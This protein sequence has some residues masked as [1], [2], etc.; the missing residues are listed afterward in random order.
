MAEIAAGRPPALANLPREPTARHL[1]R[2]PVRRPDRDLPDALRL[3][4]IKHER[5]ELIHFN[6]TASPTAAWIWHQLLEATPWSR[7]PKY[8]VH[9]K[10]AVYGSEFDGKL[11][12]LGIA[13][14]R[15]LPRASA[16]NA[17]AERSVRT[18]RTECLDHLIGINE[19][20]LRTVLAEFADYFNRD[21][22]HRGLG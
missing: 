3:F 11:A 8:L 15:T 13:G 10:D 21:R 22:P 2:R 20:H 17:V 19:Q 4:F 5:Q 12:D 16:A 7:R 6:V 9:D 1:G 18:V 14:V